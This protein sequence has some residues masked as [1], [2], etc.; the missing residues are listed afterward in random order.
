VTTLD[1]GRDSWDELA[2]R[3]GVGLEP[4]APGD[5]IGDLLTT[6]VAYWPAVPPEL[7]PRPR[8]GIPVAP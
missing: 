5:R 4:A 6:A 8:A 2:A 7:E 3:A 1:D